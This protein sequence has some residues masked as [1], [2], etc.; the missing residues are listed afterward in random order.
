[1]HRMSC[2]NLMSKNQ[3]TVDPHSIEVFIEPV[4]NRI[5]AM[6]TQARKLS[7]YQATWSYLVWDSFHD[8]YRYFVANERVQEKF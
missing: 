7:L 8:Y 5:S 4:I 6:K 1:M 2:E 3:E